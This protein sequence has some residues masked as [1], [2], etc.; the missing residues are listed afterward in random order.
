[1]GGKGGRRKR[2]VDLAAT[3]PKPLRG[4]IHFLKTKCTTSCDR[5]TRRKRRHAIGVANASPN[6]SSTIL[7]PIAMDDGHGVAPTE[8]III[9][10]LIMGFAL[11]L[12]VALNELDAAV[13]AVV[14]SLATIA[15]IGN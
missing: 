10:A 4:V 5:T 14:S 11:A 1:M 8:H 7:D 15:T 13:T 3:A 12:G 9:A 2:A 6:H